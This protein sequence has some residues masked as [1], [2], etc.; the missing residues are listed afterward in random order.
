MLLSICIRFEQ[1]SGVLGGTCLL[2]KFHSTHIL[3][4]VET[5]NPLNFVFRPLNIVAGPKII[6]TDSFEYFLPD[7]IF[8]SGTYSYFC[9]QLQFFHWVCL[10]FV[11]IYSMTKAISWLTCD[12]SLSLLF[13]ASSGNIGACSTNLISTWV[14][15]SLSMCGNFESF[16]RT[17]HNL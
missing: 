14:H 17:L 7:S 2:G 6:S 12:F 3:I 4:L 13:C 11:R 5:I 15:S 9:Q 1:A 8:S 16:L 10:C